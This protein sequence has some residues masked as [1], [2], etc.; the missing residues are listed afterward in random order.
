MSV[1]GFPVCGGILCSSM[2][3]HVGSTRMRTAEQPIRQKN[4]TT[5]IINLHCFGNFEGIKKMQSE[6][7]VAARA[8]YIRTFTLD[9]VVSQFSHVFPCCSSMGRK[10][11][12]RLQLPQKPLAPTSLC[13]SLHDWPWPRPLSSRCTE[14]GRHAQ[15]PAELM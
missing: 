2:Y 3:P 10:F 9:S 6:S 8:E 7:M 11:Q 4:N 13:I 5:H 15:T 1:G 14:R 12:K